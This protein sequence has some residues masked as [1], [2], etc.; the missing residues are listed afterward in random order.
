[1]EAVE[2]GMNDS[3]E[4]L[5]QGFT[6]CVLMTFADEDGRQNYL[7]HAEHEALKEVFVPILDEIVVFD[8]KLSREIRSNHYGSFRRRQHR[9]DNNPNQN[10]RRETSNERGLSQTEEAPRPPFDPH[11]FM[12]KVL[13]YCECPQ[14]LRRHFFPMHPDLQFAGLLAPI[15]APHHVRA[16]DECKY[17]EGVVMDKLGPNQRSL[18]NCGIRGKPVEIDATLQPGIR[19]TVQLEA[20]DYHAR[21]A[22]QGKVVSP[23]AP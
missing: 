5:N 21:G 18:V 17:R 7:P 1:M 23:A 14:Y 4:M 16:E 8:D 13:Q 15:D 12:A 9:E 3:P 6:H 11:G 10:E 19:C 22:I 20:A 2:W